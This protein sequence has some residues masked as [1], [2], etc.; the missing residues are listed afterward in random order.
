[1]IHSGELL[2]L[3]LIDTNN[4]MYTLSQGF[5]ITMHRADMLTDYGFK[6]N[7]EVNY[8]LI[9]VCSDIRDFAKCLQCVQYT[10]TSG[11]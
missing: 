11:I 4:L 8:L 10:S 9:V 3:N 5:V 6:V 2:L 7:L 1:V